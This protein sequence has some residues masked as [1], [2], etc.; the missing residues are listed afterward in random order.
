[1]QRSSDGF[2][3]GQRHERTKYVA[4]IVSHF[5][6][7]I[8]SPV[9]VVDFGCGV[10]TWLSA[11]SCLGTSKVTGLDGDYVEREFLVIDQNDFVPCDLSNLPRSFQG[12][13]IAISLEV[14][15]HLPP[16]KADDFV[17]ALTLAAPV[18]LFSA[19]IP[20]QGGVNHINEQWQ[21]YWKRLF[22]GKGFT[23]FDCIRPIIWDDVNVSY[24]YKQNTLLYISNDLV[25]KYLN[26][27]GERFLCKFPDVVHPE[28]YLSKAI[29]P[30]PVQTSFRMLL[31]SLKR[32][33]LS[34]L[35]KKAV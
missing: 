13:D 24:W 19:A 34:S 16:Q 20:W 5:L 26:L 4:E 29:R 28:L 3:Y 23:A 22:H 2:F 33:V 17:S 11:F 15:E 27:I 32:S 14:A 1:M 25:D 31:S 18:V 6:Y 21:S 35:L 12:Y 30:L 10:G 7:K 8:F 9:S